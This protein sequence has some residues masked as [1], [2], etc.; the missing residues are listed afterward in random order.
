M[1]DF[2]PD[3]GEQRAWRRPGEMTILSNMRDSLARRQAVSL[4]PFP[5]FFIQGASVKGLSNG[6]CNE[7]SQWVEDPILQ[8][9]WRASADQSGGTESAAGGELREALRSL[10][11]GEDIEQRRYRSANG[12]VAAG[13]GAV[14]S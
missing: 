10:E 14:S 2:E 3:N 4:E 5:A 8:R 11:R 6:K 1:A 13:A 12:L 9:G 7:V